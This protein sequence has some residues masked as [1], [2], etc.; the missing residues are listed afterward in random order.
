MR[1]ISKFHDYYDSVMIY[2][3]DKTVVYQ[4]EEK[5]IFDA[6][7]KT[8]DLELYSARIGYY[9]N[10]IWERKIDPFIIVFCGKVYYTFIL[11]NL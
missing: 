7:I 6:K 3:Q 9:K 5:K 4:R 1:I 8:K 10:S 2:G 11:T